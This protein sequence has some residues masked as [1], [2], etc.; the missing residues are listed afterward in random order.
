M[1]VPLPLD[2]ETQP[3]SV[4]APAQAQASTKVASKKANNQSLLTEERIH[5]EDGAE[6]ACEQPVSPQM[7]ESYSS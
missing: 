7:L 4:V 2:M 5:E 6:C 1:F 3:M